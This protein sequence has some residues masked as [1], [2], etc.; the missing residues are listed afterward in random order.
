[1]KSISLCLNNYLTFVAKVDELCRK[2]TDSQAGH[3]TCRAGCSGCCRH[4][5]LFPVEAYALSAAASLVPTEILRPARALASSG[6]TS[7]CPLLHDNRCLLYDTRPIICRTHGL[8]L[9]V[10]RS[11]AKEID[12]CPDNFQGASAIPGDAIINLETLNQALAA[13]NALFLKDAA[14]DL[15]PGRDRFSIAEA[16]LELAPPDSSD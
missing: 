11:G 2:I 13:I 12:F 1:M 3:I 9:L 8:P 14:I 10:E 6:E 15:P 5:S 4:L 7:R 16:L